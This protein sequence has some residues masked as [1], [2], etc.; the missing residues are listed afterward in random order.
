MGEPARKAALRLGEVFEA[1]GQFVLRLVRRM[2][3]V[4]GEVEDVTQNGFIVVHRQREAFKGGSL[5]SW[6]FAITRRVVADHRKRAHHKRELAQWEPPEQQAP[7]SQEQHV[8]SLQLQHLIE[9]TLA[10]LPQEQRDVFV[11]FELE[12]L[13]MAEV[14]A[15]VGCPLK[16]AYARLYAA[17]KRVREQVRMQRKE[18]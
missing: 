18:S 10:R 4:E 6:L 12:E 17:R 13:S 7:P 5:R 15:A 9:A 3:V 11:L 14:A 1:H 8:E 16:T 2:G